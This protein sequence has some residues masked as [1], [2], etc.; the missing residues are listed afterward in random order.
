MADNRRLYLLILPALTNLIIINYLPMYGVQI[1]FKNYKAVP[2]YCRH[3]AG[4][5][6]ALPH[7]L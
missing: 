6:E 3:R 2:G 4:G 1:A 7:F 5:A